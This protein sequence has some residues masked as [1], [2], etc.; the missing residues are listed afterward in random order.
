MKKIL[1]FSLCFFC[2]IV[3]SK[4]DVKSDDIFK[5][6]FY[7]GGVGGAG[8]TTW[9][10]LVPSEENKNN[11]MSVSTPISVKEGGGVWGVFA[12][13]EITPFFAIEA[14]YMRFP[15]ALVIF[16]EDSLFA[17]EQNGL[18]QLNTETQTGSVMA[19]VMLIIPKTSMRIYSGAGV[20]NVWRSDEIN[21]G[22]RVSPTFAFGANINFNERVMFELGT[23]YTAGYG[24]SEINPAKDFIPFVYSFFAKLAL[25]V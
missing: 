18:T 16:D 10:G 21:N 3:F 14:N 4:S 15:N 7:F 13:Y 8:S 1:F 9:G 22:Y 23:N 11:A 12:G 25:R 24:E 6:K 20:A 19:K 5:Y 2:G 17:F